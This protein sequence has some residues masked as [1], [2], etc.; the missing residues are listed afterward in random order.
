MRLQ[1]ILDSQFPLG[2]FAHSWG[3]E[4]YSYLGTSVDDLEMLVRNTARMGWGK[5]DLAAAALGHRFAFSEAELAKLA[6]MVDAIKLIPG[7]RNASLQLGRRMLSLMGRL[8]S[9]FT[10]RVGPPHHCVV[11]GAAGGRLGIPQRELLV[12]FAQSNAMACLAAA[13]RCMRLSPARAQQIL[14]ALQPE[15]IDV[16]DEAMADPEAAMYT[17]TPA[18]D[19]RAH[20][21]ASLYSRLFQS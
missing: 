18:L 19:I 5:L 21:Q 8:H 15:L 17:C 3:I 6:A 7:P 1:Q 12:G 13:T 14:A 10:L 4:T 16:A 20:Q 11:V 2:G 9:E